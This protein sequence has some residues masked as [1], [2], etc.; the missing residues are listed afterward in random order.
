QKIRDLGDPTLK[1]EVSLLKQLEE[2]PF[3]FSA[4]RV[5]G[6]EDRNIG[7]ICNFDLKTGK[8]GLSFPRTMEFAIR[9]AHQGRPIIVIEIRQ[10]E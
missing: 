1:S 4:I 10:N 7:P 3:D 9:Q 8:R 2:A 6:V 5:D